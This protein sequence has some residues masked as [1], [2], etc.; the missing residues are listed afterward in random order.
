MRSRGG[1]IAY[2][3]GMAEEMGRPYQIVRLP[4]VWLSRERELGS[5]VPSPTFAPCSQPR[6]R[7]HAN[8]KGSYGRTHRGGGYEMRTCGYT[9]P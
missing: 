2:F 4:Q 7:T 6:R 1:A 9:L 3:K 5:F 8:R